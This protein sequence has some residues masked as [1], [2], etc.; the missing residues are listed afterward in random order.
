MKENFKQNQTLK[1]SPSKVK[2]M[3]LPA[4]FSI[5]S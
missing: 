4:R 1:L 5:L 3:S 2:E